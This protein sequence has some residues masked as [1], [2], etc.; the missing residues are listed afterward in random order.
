MT[1]E[2]TTDEQL[3]AFA[4]V[5]MRR[6]GLPVPYKNAIA[7]AF[8]ESSSLRQ[9]WL[10]WYVRIQEEADSVGLPADGGWAIRSG[11]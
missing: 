10:A 5:M 6:G 4:V 2:R 1:R 9:G 3:V 8:K 7:A 11:G